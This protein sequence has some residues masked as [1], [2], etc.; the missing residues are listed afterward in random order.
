[1]TFPTGPDE[2]GF[3][4]VVLPVSATRQKGPTC[5]VVAPACRY[6]IAL[7][8]PVV[9]W[10]G[11]ELEGDEEDLLRSEDWCMCPLPIGEPVLR[12]E[13]RMFWLD[14][15]AGAFDNV[16]PDELSMALQNTLV[17]VREVAFLAIAR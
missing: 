16:T 12:V 9:V 6:G 13:L 5:M 15:R 14:F 8:R 4:P 1:M 10:P 3:E 7:Y 2:V 11:G 17:H